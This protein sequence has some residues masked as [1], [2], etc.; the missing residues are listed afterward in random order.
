AMAQGGTA[1]AALNAANEVAVEAFLAERIRFT[2]IPRVIEQTLG[3]VSCLEA[4][5]LDSVLKTDALARQEAWARV[6]GLQAG[7]GGVSLE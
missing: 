1:P 2:D 4:A 7:A 6:S 5:S 3:A